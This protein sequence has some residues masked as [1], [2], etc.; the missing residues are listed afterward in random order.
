MTNETGPT[1]PLPEDEF[2]AI[3]SKVPRLTVDIVLRNATG[4]VYLTKRAIP[5]CQ[6]QWH[7]PGGTVRFGEPLLGAVRRI[8]R[9][10]LDI[11]VH[12]ATGLGYV[13][14]PSHYQNGLDSPVAMVFEVTGY[15]GV[16]DASSEAAGGDWFTVLPDRMHA[17]ED[18]FLLDRGYLT[19][20][21]GGR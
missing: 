1:G 7:L 10:E 5:P 15:S 13:E 14:Y 21:P 2:R 17:D 16:P 20:S 9:R 8:A 19:T 3:Y 11:D 6:G 12:A 4:A 18:R